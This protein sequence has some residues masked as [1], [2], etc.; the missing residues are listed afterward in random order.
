MT[1]WRRSRGV[2]RGVVL[3]LSATALYT[4]RLLKTEIKQRFVGG[5]FLYHFRE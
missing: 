3:P 1:T 4:P 5:T 2:V